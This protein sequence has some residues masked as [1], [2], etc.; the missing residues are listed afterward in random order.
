MHGHRGWT[1]L[2]DGV[3]MGNQTLGDAA[4]AAGDGAAPAPADTDPIGDVCLPHRPRGVVLF[5]DGAENNS[6]GQELVSSD[7]PGDGIDTTLDDLLNLEVA[8]AA[9]PIYTIG[10]GSQV[11]GAELGQLS[12]STGGRSLEP[13]DDSQLSDSFSVIGDYASQSYQVCVD[14]PHQ[15]CGDLWIE[16][17]AQWTDGDQ[18]IHQVTHRQVHARCPGQARGRSATLMLTLSD[19][20]V[21]QAVAQ[22]LAT[23]A[24]DWVSPVI[25]PSVL[26]VLDDDNHG[27]SVGEG[28]YLRDLL[29]G[30]G[31]QV[32]LIDEP[33]AGLA[34]TDVAG[35]DVV[36][37][38]N[39]GYPMDDLATFDTLV[40]LSSAGA[41]VVLSGD[42]M[43]QSFGGGFSLAELTH[44][45]PVDNGTSYCGA[46]IDN[47]AGENY[48]VTVTGPHPV[49]GDLAGT[50]FLYGDDI[51]TA[52]ARGEG[53]AVLATA[54]VDGAAGCPEKPVIV[55]FDPDAPAAA[56][57]G[58][59]ARR[60]AAG[61]GGSPGGPGAGREGRESRR[62][63]GRRARGARAAAPRP[64]R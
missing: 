50:S 36:W 62:G 47:D 35:R 39:P 11:D 22:A 23:R 21:P 4:G 7:Y 61:R 5:T 30:A 42:D 48:R 53:E 64:G 18:T 34:P 17:D 44:L 15:T 33:A 63:R 60:G 56:G 46:S 13:Q 12:G 24:V 49:V 20:Q 26:V 45:D 9:T 37:F 59:A 27:E 16:V 3:R 38:T 14:V 19:P 8:G 57:G 52:T 55:A 6:A 41:G 58:A 29:A 10:L 2:W 28:V 1:A 43:S 54:S 25:S 32:T 40:G 31:Y 51:D